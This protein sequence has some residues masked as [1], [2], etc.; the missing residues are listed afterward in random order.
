MLPHV[1]NFKWFSSKGTNSFGGVGILVHQEI[2][3]SLIEEAV[4][5]FLIKIE[6]LNEKKFVA[7]IYVSP[8]SI[9]PLELFD[10][11]KDKEIFIFG[12]FNV[13]HEDWNCECNNVSGKRLKEWL[14][15]N[16]FV[17]LHPSQPTSNRSNSVIDFGIR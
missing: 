8:G 11:H 3:T 9:P 17:I 14:L 12:D 7:S 4:N 1:P 6:I 10:K 13:K 2:R 15:V 5:L 16:G